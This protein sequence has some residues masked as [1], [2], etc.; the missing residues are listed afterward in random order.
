MFRVRQEALSFVYFTW[1]EDM[2]YGCV[3]ILA[4]EQN[5]CVFEDFLCWEN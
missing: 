3:F 1:Q 5:N 2:V 4:Q